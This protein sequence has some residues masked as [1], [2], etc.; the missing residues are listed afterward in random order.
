M[1]DEFILHIEMRAADLEHTG[2]SRDEALRRAR[3][4]FG[5]VESFKEEARLA[6]GLG[7]FDQARFSWLDVK[8]ALRMLVKHPGLTAVATFALAVGIPV[9]LAPLHLA[10]A[11]EAPLPVEDGEEIRTLRLWNTETQQ[12]V[13]ATYYQYERLRREVRSFDIL[14]A[15][16]SDT[17]NVSMRGEADGGGG[18]PVLGASV[19]SSTFDLLREPPLLGRSLR[20]EDEEPGAPRVVVVGHALWQSRLAGGLDVVGQTLLIGGVPHLI[21]GVMPEGFLF[22]IAQQLWI[23]LTREPSARPGAGFGMR[24][25]GRMASGITEERAHAEVAAL[26]QRLATEHPET[27]ERLRAEVVPFAFTYIGIARGGLHAMGEFYAFQFLAIVLLLVAC[28]NVALLVFAR[29]VTRYRELAVRTALGAARGRVLAQMFAESLVPALLAAAVGLVAVDLALAYAGRAARNAGAI[30]PYWLDLG[31]TCEAVVW[32][33]L[34]AA[35]SAIVA[36]VAPTLTL[37]GKGIVQNI[38]R[39]Q[40]GRSGIRFGRVTSALIVAD[41]ALAVAVVGFALGLSD[42]IEDSW[43]GDRDVGI[44]AGE[45]LAASVRL[46]KNQLSADLAEG[47]AQADAAFAARLAATQS[48]LVRELETEP[49]V[50]GV[51]VG[52]AL[53]RMDHRSRRVVVE[54]TETESGKAPGRYVRTARVDVDFF[55]AL[56]TPILAGRPFDRSDLDE[57]AS[58]AIVNTTFVNR[59]LEGRNPIGR[60]VRVVTGVPGEE[61]RWY[62][63]VGVV[64]RLGMNL[65][66]PEADAGLYLPAAAG[67]IHPLVLGIHLGMP[68]EDFSPRLRELVAAIDPTAILGAPKPLHRVFQGDWYLS[69]AI[70]GGL[71]LLVGTLVALAASALYAI[72][73]FTISERTREIGIRAALGAGTV[74]IVFS[75]LQRSLLQI[76]FGVLLGMPLAAWFFRT[77]SGLES[78]GAELAATLAVGA[79]S[80]ALLGLLSCVAP[81]RRLL[82]IEPTEAL[83]V[84]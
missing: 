25:Y 82:R 67:T 42:R 7:L 11:I 45:Y 62:E 8:L 77:W 79:G 83:R 52:D 20:P 33:L 51:A 14:G 55:R 57:H 60:R 50:L 75:V 81:T 13:P 84:E 26:G 78:M 70:A 76:T 72:L 80:M 15:S 16:R 64:G 43:S 66:A 58:V 28:A 69:V 61:E 23:P 59:D 74:S 18:A 40:A 27:H 53:P 12:M 63:I 34:L 22:P 9:G 71:V 41:V 10:K 49:G 73:S 68:P 3:I 35:A 21:V 54:G 1:R 65:V 48:A 46:P 31:V 30:I 32:A 17:Y 44:P 29:T 4:E 5:S 37:T 6:R 19:T 24:I 39:A 56:E 38:Q 36:G 47:S 2:L